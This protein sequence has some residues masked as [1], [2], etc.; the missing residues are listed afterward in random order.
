MAQQLRSMG[1]QCNTWLPKKYGFPDGKLQR[2]KMSL[3]HLRAGRVRLP[4]FGADNEWVLH[5]IDQCARFTGLTEEEDD[6]VDTMT[7]AISI[8]RQRGGGRDV[9]V[10]EMVTWR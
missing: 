1:I 2:V 6:S 8:W 4:V 5:F 9:N 7:M 3:F 10:D